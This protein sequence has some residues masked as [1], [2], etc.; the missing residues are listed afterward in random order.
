[1]SRSEATGVEQSLS[2]IFERE[3]DLRKAL[4]EEADSKHAFEV[5]Q[6]K[7]ILKAEGTEKVKAAT[8]LIACQVEYLDYLQK[9]AV[10]VFTKEAIQDA[11]QA[12]SARQSLL[13]A[14]SRADLGYAV[15][16]RTV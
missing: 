9:K 1:M 16:R 4:I 8:A 14:S 13:T 11:Q 7:E 6:A 2:M 5:K 15:D 12:L 10:A 3:T